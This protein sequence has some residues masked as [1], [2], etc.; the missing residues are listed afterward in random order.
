MIISTFTILILA[1]RVA[2]PN[3]INLMSVSF[4]YQG[5][6]NSTI[7][8]CNLESLCTRYQSSEEML[9]S[10]S[11]STVIVVDCEGIEKKPEFMSSCL[12]RSMVCIDS[13]MLLHNL[14]FLQHVHSPFVSYSSFYLYLNRQYPNITC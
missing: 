8:T 3:T 4:H 11:Q 10:N 13:S 14:V 2:R 7:S 12:P 5:K 1:K 9:P 6:R